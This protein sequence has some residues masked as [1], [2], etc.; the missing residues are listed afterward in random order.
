MLNLRHTAEFQ[1]QPIRIEHMASF[2]RRRLFGN[3]GKE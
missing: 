3:T 2:L 1:Q